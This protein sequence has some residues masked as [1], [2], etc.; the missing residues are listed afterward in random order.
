M[1]R[2]IVPS[3]FVLL[4][5]SAASWGKSI[6]LDLH[7]K[8]MGFNYTNGDS[9]LIKGMG[10]E[11]GFLM[12]ESTRP[13]L[14][15]GL[16]VAGKNQSENG[17]FDISLGGRFYNGS[18]INAVALGGKAR[19]S[20]MNRVGLSAHFYF[21]PDITTFGNSDGITDFMIRADYQVIPQAYAYIGHR[22][23]DIKFP[24]STVN[25]DNNFHIG[26]KLDF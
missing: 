16:S 2:Y 24:G 26:I 18:S 1:K 3:F 23:I 17:T 22:Q 14:H 15:L 4:M 19:F 13:L 6:E 8:A 7:N 9:I 20:P 21:A 10:V 12:K 5:V 25:V 11:A